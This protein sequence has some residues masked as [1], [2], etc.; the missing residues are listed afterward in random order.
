[1]TRSTIARAAAWALLGAL[2]LAPRPGAAQEVE[3]R[4]GAFMPV[5]GISA[6]VGAQIKGGIEVAVER[7]QQQG[8][9]IGDKPAK[10]RVIW[11]DT[12]STST[13]S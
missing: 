13:R 11:Y 4:L 6:D 10:I 5:S 7:A 1:M 12:S 3:V 2:L 9:R 8:I